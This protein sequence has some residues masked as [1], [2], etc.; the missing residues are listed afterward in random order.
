MVKMLTTCS[1]SLLVV[2]EF[3]GP[4]VV[5]VHSFLDT[6]FYPGDGLERQIL[7]DHELMLDD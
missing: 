7:E 4:M 1:I 5:S 6:Q 2:L 3:L